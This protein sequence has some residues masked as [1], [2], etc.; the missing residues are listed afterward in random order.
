VCSGWPLPQ[1]EGSREDVMAVITWGEWSPSHEMIASALGCSL[2]IIDILSYLEGWSVLQ[3]STSPCRKFLSL[4]IKMLSLLSF[5]ESKV[6]AKW[7]QREWLRAKSDTKWKQGCQA[8]SFF[9]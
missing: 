4:V 7:L 2:I 8:S 1:F 5:L 9:S 6:I 3:V